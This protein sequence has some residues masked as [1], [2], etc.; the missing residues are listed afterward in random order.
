[1]ILDAINAL[2]DVVSEAR[3]ANVL[4]SCVIWD[5]TSLMELSE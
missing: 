4:K 3:L 2:T 5:G 1:M